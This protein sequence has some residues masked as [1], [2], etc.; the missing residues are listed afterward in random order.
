MRRLSIRSLMSFVVVSAVGLAALRNASDLWAGMMLLAALAALGAA[1]LGSLILRGKERCWWAGFAVFSGGYL[2]LAV[3]PWFRENPRPL[4]GTTH[5]L[6]Y[7]QQKIHPSPV[8]MNADLASAQTAHDTLVAQFT[9]LKHNMRNPNNP[10]IIALQA[11]LSSV[12]QEITVLRRT[13]TREQFQLVGHSLFAILAGLVG[14]LIGA[15]F[16]DRRERS[17]TTEHD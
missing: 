15:R 5:L 13:P 17:G 11:S 7:A 10:A 2:A 3:G 12:D 9:R 4:L 1:T 16:F 6:T 14:G 8:L